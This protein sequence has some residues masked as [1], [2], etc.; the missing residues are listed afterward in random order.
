[1]SIDEAASRVNCSR[2][3]FCRLFKKVLGMSFVEYVHR[4]RIDHA[5]DLLLSS[6]HAVAY[7]AGEVGFE[8]VSHFNRVFRRFTGITPSSFRKI[9][10]RELSDSGTPGMMPERRTESW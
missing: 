7:I 2:Y 9:A 8:N 1:L 3:Y 10:R 6:D 5:K 4:M